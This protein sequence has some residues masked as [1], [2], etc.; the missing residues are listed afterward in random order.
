MY[1]YT[2]VEPLK[3]SHL[4]FGAHFLS[5]LKCV[6]RQ[7]LLYMGSFVCADIYVA[8]L[9]AFFFINS[10]PI[11]GNSTFIVDCG[12]EVS[13]VSSFLLL[14]LDSFVGD[15]FL[16]KIKRKWFR[17]FEIYFIMCKGVFDIYWVVLLVELTLEVVVK[18]V[19][20]MDTWAACTCA[21]ALR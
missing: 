7:V 21:S 3:L 1:N 20:M 9:L 14:L 10:S 6:T 17:L 15:I 2:W 8:N 5:L 4:R 12:V 18:S 11:V 16:T 13:I 19:S